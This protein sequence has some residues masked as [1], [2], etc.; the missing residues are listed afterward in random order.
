MDL[1][2]LTKKNQEFI[3]IATNQLIQDGKSDDEIKTIL[4]EVLPTIVE[5]QKKGLTARALFGAPTVWAASFTEKDSDKNAEQT[6]KND[7]PWLMWLDT[8]LLFI[9]IVALL[10]TVIDFLNSTTTSSR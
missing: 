3:H 6:D 8:S 4:E 9:G 7:N 10:D 1:T 2:K 5:N